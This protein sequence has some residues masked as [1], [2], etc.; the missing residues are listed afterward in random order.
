M[1]VHLNFEA[2]QYFVEL[3]LLEFNWNPL[4]SD[5][6]LNVYARVFAMHLTFLTELLKEFSIIRR[7]KTKKTD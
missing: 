2:I 1:S 6:I 7:T 5:D 3:Y 4:F